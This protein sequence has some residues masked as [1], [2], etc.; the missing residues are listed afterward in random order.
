VRARHL[1]ARPPGRVLN[2]LHKPRAAR[3]Q[4]AGGAGRALP[5]TVQEGGDGS[6]FE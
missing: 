4:A 6:R 5:D 3:R 2:I 1:D